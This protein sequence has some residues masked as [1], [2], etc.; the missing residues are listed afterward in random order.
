M[1]PKL[2]RLDRTRQSARRHR[3]QRSFRPELEAFE[4]RC[5][6][7]TFTWFQN[8]DGD[9]DD[10]SKW[11]DQNG[12]PGVPGPNDD[13][14][15][16]GTGFTVTSSADNTVRSLNANCRLTVADGTFTVGDVLNSSS[17]N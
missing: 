14:I 6:L 9:F 1:F 10:A 3:G 15:I 5:L 8:V 7:S 17:F 16:N 12:N 2:F 4:D 11:Q 13:A